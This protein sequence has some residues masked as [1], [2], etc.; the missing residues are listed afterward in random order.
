M[1]TLAVQNS[2]EHIYIWSLYAFSDC[3]SRCSV[4]VFQFQELAVHL[5]TENCRFIARCPSD[6]EFTARWSAESGTEFRLL[7]V[8]AEDQF[9]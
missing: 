5:L 7:Q 6:L 2:D 4:E 1:W 8:T 9:F 3:R